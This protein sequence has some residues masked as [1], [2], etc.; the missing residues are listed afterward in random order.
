M[1]EKEILKKFGANIR[2]ERAR[3]NYS[4]EHMIE[5]AGLSSTSHISDIE[6]GKK[7]PTLTTIIAIL[8]ALDIKFEDLYKE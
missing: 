3:K 4:Q 5:L 8:K 7:N 2:A 1:N 6:N